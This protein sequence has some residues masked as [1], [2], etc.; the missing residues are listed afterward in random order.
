MSISDSLST[1]H[2]A[3]ALSLLLVLGWSAFIFATSC[4]VVL[5]DELFSA[6]QTFTGATSESMNRF[7]LFWG[8]AWFTIVKGWHFAEFAILTLLVF[9]A[10]NR[11]KRFHAT[12]AILVA[13]ML[14]MIF[15]ASDEW[16]Q[17]FVP[18]RVGS[19]EDV[20]IDMAG[21][22]FAGLVLLAMHRRKTH[23]GSTTATMPT[24]GKWKT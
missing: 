5:P 21:I 9:Q 22:A 18:K 13:M 19:V 1:N 3:W 23:G 4:T 2:R 16:H 14:S 12:T 20:L 10:F 7:K 6:V 15:A 17:T 11:S 8:I 24:F